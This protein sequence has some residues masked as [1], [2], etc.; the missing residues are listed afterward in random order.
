MDQFI[1]NMIDVLDCEEE[2]TENTVLAEIEEWDSLSYVAFMAMAKG[3][4]GK[5]VVAQDVRNA[6]TISDLYD[7]V[8]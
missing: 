5:Q 1:E 2:L 3:I 7:L 4:Y 6:K 8:K